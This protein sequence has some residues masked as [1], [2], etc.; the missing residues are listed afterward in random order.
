MEINY[1]RE[2][3]LFFIDLDSMYVA[4]SVYDLYHE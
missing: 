4:V 1:Q 3:G 2:V